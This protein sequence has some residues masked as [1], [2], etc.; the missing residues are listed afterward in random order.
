MK[1][2]IKYFIII[3]LFQYAMQAQTTYVL[4]GWNDLGMHCSNKNFSKIA[5][6]PPYNNFYAQLIKKEPGQDPQIVTS[7]ISIEYSIPGNTYSVGKTDF[8]TYAQQ[9]FG[10]AN[11]LPANVGL[12]GKGLTGTL[13]PSGDHFSASG[14]PLTPF[15]DNSLTKEN[16][17]QLIHLIAK[18][19][20][21]STVLATTDA[22]IPV[23]NDMGCVQSGCHNS[24][25]DILNRHEGV[26]GFNR[27]GPV[28]CANCHQ[29]NALGTTGKGEA[30]PFSQ[31]MHSVHS[32]LGLPNTEATCFKCHPGP[33][34]QCL[35]G[36]MVDFPPPTTPMI[37][38]DCHGTLANVASTIRN[39]R[40]PWLDEPTCGSCHGSNFSTETGKLFKE[41]KGHGGL[42]CSACHGSPHGI[43]PT[44]VAN[45]NIQSINLQGSAGTIR[46]CTV[47]HS[48]VPTGPGPHG[49]Y[50]SN[51]N[52]PPTVSITSPANGT[53]FT[54][55]SN[56]TINASASD[57]DGTIGNV[58][59]YAGTTLLG[60][61]IS[62]PYSFT[63]NNAPSGGYVLTAVAKD[64]SNATTVSNQVN[65]TVNSTSGNT[66]PSVSIT[67]PSNGASFSANSNIT[68]NAAA[69]DK[70]G[71]V[72]SV[73]FY[74]G[75]TL[76][77]TDNNSPYSYVWNNVQS[78]KYGLTAVA[79]DN[80]GAKTTSAIVNITVGTVNSNHPPIV[81]ITS[82]QNG[83]VFNSNSSITISTSTSD[84]DGRVVRVAFYRDNQ[85]LGYDNRS[86]FNYRW[87][88][89]PS[90]TYSLKAIATDNDGATTTST[91]V[92]ITV[93]SR[94]RHDGEDLV[95]RN[96]PNPF[97]PSTEIEF[98]LQ[99]EE[100]VTLKIYNMIG[101]EVAVLINNERMSAGDHSIQFNASDQVSGT[102]IC[103]LQ[104]G[105]ITEF[106]KMIL[107]K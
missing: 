1:P 6:L 56:I 17:Y 3:F 38:Q 28:L 72:T 98:N 105:P 75:T 76:L 103:K 61:V 90:G 45:D 46:E 69:S 48:T 57:K 12:T 41:S 99:S 39:G 55:G 83:A 36:A 101:Q 85:L 4:I 10:L 87:Y 32:K 65:I 59:F 68:I 34:T 79:T 106:R 66:P 14:I 92:Q 77:A 21:T 23:S 53:V 19:S 22:V 81:S 47:C 30:P 71:S 25:Q 96:F 70:D 24:E 78:G 95:V 52:I 91:P 73:A 82:P 60:I 94:H 20:G 67:S 44:R 5:V 27:N 89:V 97:N 15:P 49:I 93:R 104:M 100:D 86:P 54:A 8:W 80:N 43:W 29:D 42:Y 58:S 13:D 2:I 37:C 88:N 7:G 40:R 74:S 35:R 18:I 62:P 63:W 50:A 84:P 11:P 33:E 26:N 9:L 51:M 107:L 102:Y 16:P 64:N 31:A